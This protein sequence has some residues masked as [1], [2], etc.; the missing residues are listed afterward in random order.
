MHGVLKHLSA[1][2]YHPVDYHISLEWQDFSLI[3]RVWSSH[4]MSWEVVLH[5]HQKL[6]TMVLNWR[7]IQLHLEQF[8]ILLQWEYENTIL[9][10]AFFTDL[11]NDSIAPLCWLVLWVLKVHLIVFLALNSVNLV[12]STFS[13][14]R[15]VTF[16]LIHW[17]HLQHS[18]HYHFL[19]VSVDQTNWWIFVVPLEMSVVISVTNSKWIARVVKHENTAPYAF[20]LCLLPN[21][22]MNGPK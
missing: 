1:T 20:V 18:F 21:F 5:L 3:L 7:K 14:L 8:G 2:Q 10:N 22:I 6:S 19:Y 9:F 15:F 11:I 17:L 13:L 12:L 16:S 4:Y